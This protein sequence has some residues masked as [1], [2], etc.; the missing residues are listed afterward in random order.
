MTDPLYPSEVARALSLRQRE[1]IIEMS[2]MEEMGFSGMCTN[3]MFLNE[4]GERLVGKHIC[5]RKPLVLSDGDGFTIEPERTRNGYVLTDFGRIVARLLKEED[6]ECSTKARPMDER[7]LL[8]TFLGVPL[9]AAR[10]EGW[11]DARWNLW[12]QRVVHALQGLPTTAEE[13]TDE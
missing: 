6:D 8:G 7:R 9:L 13:K 10:P 2:N 3:R 12:T 11:S 1:F 5:I 4:T